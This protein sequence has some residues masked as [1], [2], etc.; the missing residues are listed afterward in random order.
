VSKRLNFA[1]FGVFVFIL[2]VFFSYLVHKNIFNKFDFDTTVVLQNHMSR[3]FDDLF[4]IFSEVG[5]FEVMLVILIVVLLLVRRLFGAV[6]ALLLFVG[7]HLIELFGKLYVNHPPPPNFMLRTKQLVT[8][9]QFH[10]SSDFS[11]PSGHAGRT[12]FL[13]IIILFLILQSRKLPAWLKVSLLL[14]L[15]GYDAIMLMSRVYLGE[16]WTTDVIGGILLGGSFGFITGGWLIGKENHGK[17][18]VKAS[19]HKT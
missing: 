14:F 13:S 8:F 5:A 10:V 19:T 11:Y 18:Q 3:R 9:P 12:L 17:S 1:L 7:I 2:F 4:S 15:L 6:L 16:H